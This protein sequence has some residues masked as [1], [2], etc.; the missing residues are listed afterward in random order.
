MSAICG[1]KTDRPSNKNVTSVH[2]IMQRRSGYKPVRIQFNLKWYMHTQ[3][4][5]QSYLQDGMQQCKHI[6]KQTERAE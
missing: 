1:K 6:N 3:T 5:H 4:E 2:N